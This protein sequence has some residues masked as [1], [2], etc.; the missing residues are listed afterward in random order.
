MLHPS[1]VIIKKKYPFACTGE[2]THVVTM[3][4]VS[5]ELLD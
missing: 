2:G 4:H 5:M 1:D 3:Q